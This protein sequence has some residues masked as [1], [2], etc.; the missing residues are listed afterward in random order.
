METNEI[1]TGE[2]L[3][4]EKVW[5]TIQ[6]NARESKENDRKFEKWRRETETLR[7]KER[8]DAEQERKASEEVRGKER[9]K[10]R[11]ED[12][13]RMLD[14]EQLFTSQWGKLME[15][16]VEGDLL[17]ILNRQGFQVTD[18]SSRY[19][20]RLKDGG[21]FEF[22]LIAYNGKEVIVVEVKT[23]L[24]PDDVKT[25][26]DKLN[27]I[28]QWIPRFAENRIIGAVAWLSADSNAEVMAVKRGLFSIRATGNS[29]FITNEENFQPNIW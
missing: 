18:I 4:F 5:L 17:D 14:L 22:D 2:G 11:V 7:E 16:L 21:N 6:E 1:P 10:E 8:K 19:K 29:A 12:K 3:T 15:S 23:T 28:K 27:H 26:L 9:E 25:F 24:R 13:K 20:G